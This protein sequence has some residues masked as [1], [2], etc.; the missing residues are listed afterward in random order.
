MVRPAQFPWA[1][2]LIVAGGLLIGLAVGLVV[3]YGL[4]AP[5]HSAVFLPT[6]S[7]AAAVTLPAPA[8]VVGAPAPDFTLADLSGASVSLAGYQGQVVLLNFWATW[9]PPCKLEMPTLQQH[10]V[11]YKAQGL[12]VVGVEAGE[13]KAEVQAFATDQRLTFPILPDEKTTVTDMYR[14]SALPTTFVIDRQGLIVQQHLGMMTDTQVDG[15]L[16]EL[17]LKKP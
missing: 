15:Y 17:G 12:V 2:V 14:V 6:Q 7:G 1:S 13:P 4:P 11:D 10:Y 5:A 16:T 3:F 8:P 9:C